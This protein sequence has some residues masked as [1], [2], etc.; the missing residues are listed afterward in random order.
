MTKKELIKDIIQVFLANFILACGVALFI[1][2]NNILSG[3][4][5]GIAVAIQPLIAM[6]TQTLIILL[7]AVL[8]VVGSLFLGKGF[9]VKTALSS[10][11]YPLFVAILSDLTQHIEITSN[12]ILASIYG[13]AFVGVGVGLVFRTGASTGGM[14]IP[15]LII[16]KYT[17]IK[18]A[19]LVLIVDGLTVLLGM[20]LHG[21]E[22]ALIGI[23]SVWVS[24]LLVNKTILLGSQSAKTVM[25]ISN[26]YEELLAEITSTINR[27]AT[28]LQAQGAFTRETK[29]VIM[30]VVM[31][32]QFLILN[33]LVEH[34]DPSAFMIVSDTSE[35]QG[36][37]F[38]FQE[39]EI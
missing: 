11:I 7:T 1:L 8:F 30:V 27:G 34:I 39:D 5:A 25:I 9:M 31:N 33:R 28:I 35:V 2:P 36:E 20:L 10:V 32:K 29:P 26:K 14:D 17:N 16:H 37:G 22:A 38:T 15:P 18:L 23:I 24:A 13:G 6:D 12:P 4:V 21:V 3:G 19:T